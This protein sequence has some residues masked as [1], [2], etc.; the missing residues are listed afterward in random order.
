MKQYVQ[1]T[2]PVTS[3]EAKE[4]LVAQLG[5]IKYEAFEEADGSLKAFIEQDIFDE[6]LLKEL[7]RAH[8]L[9]YDADVLPV[10]NWNEEWEKNFQ[11]VIVD[12]FC[13]IRAGFHA[14]LADVQ[15]EIVITP[16][17]SFGTG[18]HATTE[19]M[20]RLMRAVDFTDKYVFD[21]GTGTGILAILADKMG[22][23]KILAMDNDE[24]SMQNAAENMAA[25]HCASIRLLNAGN[26]PA[27]DSFDVILA[28][29]NKHVIVD[30][31]P[32]MEKQLSSGGII[33]LSGLLESDAD[34]INKIA[35]SCGLMFRQQYSRSG[36]IALRYDKR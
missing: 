18:H 14:P 9:T 27:H 35:I 12:D 34:D 26:I 31:L 23:R 36:W 4:I 21:F 19:M 5:D 25:N 33:L 30:T 17:M 3:D 8:E 15:H 6:S 10:T 22:A 28:N 2:I 16:K 32:D 20:I 29:I 11:P 7:L 13:G 1:V 24:W